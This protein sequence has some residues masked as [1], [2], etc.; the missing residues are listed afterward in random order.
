MA[1]DSIV[2]QQI[3]IAKK[4]IE[5]ALALND[6]DAMANRALDAVSPL[7]KAAR[8]ASANAV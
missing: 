3:S 2:V 7:L 5:E 6:D 8:Q 4:I 1:T